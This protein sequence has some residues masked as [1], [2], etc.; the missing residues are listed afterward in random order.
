MSEHLASPAEWEADRDLFF[1]FPHLIQNGKSWTTW[2][3]R[4]EGVVSSSKYSTHSSKWKLSKDKNPTNCFIDYTMNQPMSYWVCLLCGSPK[5]S[6]DTYSHL[7]AVVCFICPSLIMA[8]GSLWRHL[9]SRHRKPAHLCK[10]GTQTWA[11]NTTLGKAY[12]GLAAVNPALRA[13]NL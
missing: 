13:Y 1:F 12:E 4:W 8:I 2:W 11:F 10:T 7:H 3:W 9:A 6:K 5:W